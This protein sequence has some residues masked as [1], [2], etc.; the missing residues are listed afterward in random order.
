MKEKYAK[1]MILVPREQVGGETDDTMEQFWKRRLLVDELANA[2]HV[3]RMM[4]IM[5][6]MSQ[7]RGRALPPSVPDYAAG[8]SDYFRSQ[9]QLQQLQPLHITSTFSD[10]GL[11][12]RRRVKK[13][14]PS[15]EPSVG[16]TYPPRPTSFQ[17]SVERHRRIDQDLET[18][19]NRAKEDLTEAKKTGNTTQIETAQQ[20]L[21]I[22]NRNIDDIHTQDEE[23]D[24]LS[25]HFPV[26]DKQITFGEE[27]ERGW[28]EYRQELLKER[29]DQRYGQLKRL[30]PNLGE[31]SAPPPPTTRSSQASTRPPD[32]HSFRESIDRANTI[33]RDLENFRSRAEDQVTEAERRGDKTQLKKAKQQLA[34]VLRNIDDILDTDAKID[35]LP[36]NDEQHEKTYG[37]EDR[38][39]H[40]RETLEDLN[41]R[42]DRLY[43]Q[44]ESLFPKQRIQPKQRG[45]GVWRKPRGWVEE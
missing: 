20:R 6:D 7:S 32:A 1:E 45:R 33:Q 23:I 31:F 27:D 29:R 10:R 30:Y 18:F 41:D 16:V 43:R 40:H 28:R 17:E 21:A 15:R 38:E 3:D 26:E 14:T 5:D 37:K 35:R 4:K 9:R 13:D 44:L 22:V 39:A 42:R 24:L 8:S 36:L 12:K 25:Y 19:R 2:P 34:I 11:G